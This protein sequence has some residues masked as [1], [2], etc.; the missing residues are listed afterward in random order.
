MASTPAEITRTVAAMRPDVRA[1]EIGAVL[2]ADPTLTALEVIET[3]DHAAA[4]HAAG[5][6]I[7]HD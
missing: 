1:D 4:D 3:L 7:T 2:T 5:I 6:D